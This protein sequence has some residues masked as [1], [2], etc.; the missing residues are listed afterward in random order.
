MRLLWRVE[1]REKNRALL[2]LAVIL[3]VGCL[4][5][6]AL[7]LLIGLRLLPVEYINTDIGNFAPEQ[8]EEYVLMV[9]AEFCIDQDVDRARQ[10]LAELDV[11][12]P[13]QFVAY[14]ADKHVQP[15]V[16]VRGAGR[17]YHLYDRLCLHANAVADVDFHADANGDGH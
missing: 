16:P 1:M 5:G 7:A 3:P 2:I 17:E 4:V 12:N 14:V 8:A 15:G 11:P 9:A 6:L 13:E 10:R